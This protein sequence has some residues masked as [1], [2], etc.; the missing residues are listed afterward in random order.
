MPDTA[1]IASAE[2][3]LECFRSTLGLNPNPPAL[4]CFRVGLDPV[5][6]DFDESQDYCCSGL[7]YIRILRRF[8]A[9]QQF[10]VADQFASSCQPQAWGVAFELGSFR[11]APDGVDCDA[12]KETFVNVQN[13]QQAMGDA[14]C[15]WIEHQQTNNLFFMNYML[16]DWRPFSLQGGCTGG[17]MDVLAQF[18]AGGLQ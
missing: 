5:A 6:A 4:L 11:C 3:L 15:C 13:D 9:G 12:W 10:P 16:G 14:I 7:A 1:I 18:Q 17:A 8:P 2:A